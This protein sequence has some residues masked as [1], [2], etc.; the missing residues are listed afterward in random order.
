MIERR[1]KKYIS[2]QRK[3]PVQLASAGVIFT[4]VKSEI[5]RGHQNRV[6]G[7]HMLRDK[8]PVISVTILAGNELY[9]DNF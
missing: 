5:K 7:I 3:I 1:G 9:R 8:V 6:S 4:Q 2:K